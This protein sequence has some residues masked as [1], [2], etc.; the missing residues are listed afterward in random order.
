MRSEF[1]RIP[2]PF[3]FISGYADLCLDGGA[4]SGALNVCREQN[5]SYYEAFIKD[6]KGYLR[7]PFFSLSRLCRLLD[8]ENIAFD[9]LG[10]FG[11]P[12][13][14]FRH[15]RRLGIPVGVILSVLLIILSGR[16][17]W[18][19]RIDGEERLEEQEVESI[20]AKCGLS[21]GS[22]ISSID[23]SVIENRALILSDDIAWISINLRGTVANVEIRE[24][25]IIPENEKPPAANLVADSAGVIVRFEDVRGKTAVSSGEAVSEGQLLV[26][27]ILGDE[28]SL[29]GY[30]CAEGKVF[31]E[32]EQTF[33]VD[34]LR[35]YRKKEYTGRVKCEKYLIFFKKEIKFFS[36]C[37]NLYTTYDKIDIVE[38]F[39]SP[40]GD[41][42]P[43]GIRTVKYLEYVY[44][45]RE[46]S[47]EEL[48]RL[49]KY[50]TALRLN[51]ELKDA[52]LLRKY[53]AVELCPDRCV[54]VTRVRCIKNIARTKEID[55]LS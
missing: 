13:L 36:N 27:G 32:C 48:S 6:G 43:V 23:A 5:I 4:L 54:M 14:V 34:I 31:A 15:R 26:S 18:D 29:I 1:K 19:V 33:E 39:P 20:L 38:Y 12:A 7:I 3:R 2:H 25:N 11:L 51:L 40:S 52:E 55:I 28:Q 37:G 46:R 50:Q 17:V 10:T 41:D 42:L 35:S 21:V 45:D 30:T 49:A 22:A 47:D 53:S 9:K 24:L 8:G 16:V 44:T